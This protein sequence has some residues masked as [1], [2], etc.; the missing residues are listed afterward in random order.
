M[1]QVTLNTG[2]FYF[3]LIG[4]HVITGIDLSRILSRGFQSILKIEQPDQ[5]W[6]G[7]LVAIAWLWLLFTCLVF[8][9]R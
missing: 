7:S 1:G 9:L 8:S 4:T 6:P 5:P 2:I 3:G